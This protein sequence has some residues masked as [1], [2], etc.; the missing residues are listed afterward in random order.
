[1]HTG[2]FKPRPHFGIPT[3]QAFQP[4]GSMGQVKSSVTLQKGNATYTHSLIYQDY[5]IIYPLEVPHHK[6]VHV[7]KDRVETAQSALVP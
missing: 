5:L 7:L 6:P 1:M 2:K 4:G 3:N